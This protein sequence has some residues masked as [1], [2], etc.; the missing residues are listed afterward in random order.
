MMEVVY[1]VEISVEFRRTTLKYV[2]E[3][4]TAE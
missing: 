4:K 1:L 2:P 3:D